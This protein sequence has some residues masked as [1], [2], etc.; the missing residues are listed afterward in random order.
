MK[1]LAATPP[2]PGM[3]GREARG[4]AGGVRNNSAKSRRHGRFAPFVAEPIPVSIGHAGGGGGGGGGL[5]GGGWGGGGG[6]GGG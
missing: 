2:P 4:A 1:Q 6:G 3:R 5:G